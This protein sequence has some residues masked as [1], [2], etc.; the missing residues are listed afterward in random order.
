MLFRSKVTNVFIPEMPQMR[1]DVL[2]L[3]KAQ[4]MDM[5]L[6]PSHST[7][8]IQSV[9]M[10]M[11]CSEYPFRLTHIEGC[12]YLLLLPSGSNRQHF[13]MQFG[14]LLQELGYIVFPWSLVVNGYV[15]SLKFKVWVEL[16]QVSPQAWC[17]N[18]LIV[19]ISSFGIVLDHS[20]LTK[21]NSLESLMAVATI[22]LMVMM[23]LSGISGVV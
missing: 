9:L 15:M 10:S 12:Q 17:I 18:H 6:R 13:I 16:K 23:W 4:A 11:C 1:Q 2:E 3:N 8:G 14:G 20:S 22:S 5:R 19:A 21:S 7:N